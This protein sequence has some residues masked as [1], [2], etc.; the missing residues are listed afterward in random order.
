MNAQ[1]SGREDIIENNMFVT[2]NSDEQSIL[3]RGTTSPLEV[4]TVTQLSNDKL[5]FTTTVVLK[6]IGTTTLTSI[7]CK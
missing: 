4:K 6:N 1:S 3:W 7:Y 2:S 5:Y